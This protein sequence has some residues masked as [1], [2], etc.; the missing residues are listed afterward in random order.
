MN[1]DGAYIEYD[2]GQKGCGKGMKT[3]SITCVYT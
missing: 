3:K 1:V 2:L